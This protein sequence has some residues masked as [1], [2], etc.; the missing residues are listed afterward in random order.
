MRFAESGCPVCGR[1]EEV[2][3][4]GLGA[5]WAVSLVTCPACGEFGVTDQD[6]VNLASSRS[7]GE[8]KFFQL[9][10][11]LRERSI[12]PLPRFC[13]Q[14]GTEPYERPGFVVINVKELLG[15]WP[16]TVPER[17]DRTLCNLATLSQRAGDPVDVM[18]NVVPLAFA[19]TAK[20]ADY[21]IKALVD[22]GFL[23]REED[24]YTRKTV[25]LTPKGWGQFEKLTRGAS[26]P[27]N[28][29]F[30]AMS[31]SGDS[32]KKAMDDAY[33]QAILPAIEQAGYRARRVDLVEHNH[34]IMDEVL[35][36]IRLAPFVVADFTGHRNGVYFEAGFARGL[37]IP[38]IHTCREDE[39]NKAHFDTKQLNHVIW[40]TPEELRKR[41]H[42][43]IVGTIGRGPHPPAVKP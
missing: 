14:D 2:K 21:N 17:L 13:L 43:R 6:Y 4:E 5:S 34:W 19:E 18:S 28:P 33:Q 40:T 3:V 8:W 9:S 23:N 36:E 35:A 31:F 42:N 16:R 11:L 15:Q 32:Q 10:A 12:R 27:E 41:L 39:F 30:V 38:V 25:I 26:A 24:A 29:A 37:G 7:K 20:E 1:Q 22:L